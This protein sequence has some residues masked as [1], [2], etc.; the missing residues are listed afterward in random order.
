M[1]TSALYMHVITHIHPHTCR[2]R[3][4]KQTERMNPELQHE[5]K[6]NHTEA[7]DS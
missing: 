5:Y 1:P 4:R 2:T 7:D 6:G 3:M